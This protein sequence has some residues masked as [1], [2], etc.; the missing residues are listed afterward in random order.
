[1]WCEVCVGVYGLQFGTLFASSCQLG[2][3]LNMW[4][5]YLQQQD[6]FLVFFLAL[7]ILV[8]AKYAVL[9]M[10]MSLW[11]EEGILPKLLLGARKTF[12][13]CV[14]MSKP[15]TTSVEYSNSRV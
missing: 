9:T 15:L 6:Q 2:V 13:L 14:D 7:V 8:N 3:T 12:D 10:S 1:M 4:D 5:V 11:R